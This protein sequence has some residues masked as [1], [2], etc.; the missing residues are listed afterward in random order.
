M[1]WWRMHCSISGMNGRL[2]QWC[3]LLEARVMFEV[4][5]SGNL[6]CAVHA[7]LRSLTH[8]AAAAPLAWQGMQACHTGLFRTRGVHTVGTP[9]LH[10]RLVVYSPHCPCQARR[11]G[12]AFRFGTVMDTVSSLLASQGTQMLPRLVW[13]CWLLRARQICWRPL[14]CGRQR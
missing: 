6:H 14:W 8:M 1:V 12:G 9:R 4:S 7:K 10:N 11:A 5:T 3:L 2:L 13:A